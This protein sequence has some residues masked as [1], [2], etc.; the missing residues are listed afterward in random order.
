MNRLQLLLERR[1]AE[2]TQ[3]WPAA[4]ALL[5]L[6]SCVSSGVVWDGRDWDLEPNTEMAENVSSSYFADSLSD[7]SLVS[8]GHQSLHLPYQEDEDVDQEQLM[9][10]AMKLSAA[11]GAEQ[12]YAFHF[13]FEERLD[14]M[15]YTYVAPAATYTFHNADFGTVIH[16]RAHAHLFARNH[17]IRAY[18]L[19]ENRAGATRQ[20]LELVLGWIEDGSVSQDGL[21]P[22]MDRPKDDPAMLWSEVLLVQ[23]AHHHAD[24]EAV[25]LLARMESQLCGIA[26]REDA[27]GFALEAHAKLEPLLIGSAAR[28]RTHLVVDRAGLSIEKPDGFDTQWGTTTQPWCQA[29]GA[30][31]LGAGLSDY[32]W[33]TLGQTLAAYARTDGGGHATLSLMVLPAGT[34]DLEEVWVG[35]KEVYSSDGLTLYE[36]TSMEIEGGRGV[37]Y[38]L[39]RQVDILTYEARTMGEPGMVIKPHWAVVTIG[40]QSSDGASEQLLQEMVESIRWEPDFGDRSLL[41]RSEIRPHNWFSSG[42]Q[43]SSSSFERPSRSVISS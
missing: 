5:L 30:A 16:R 28:M 6:S 29:D 25:G 36:V 12:C 23:Y 2:S 13:S 15:T 10:E 9:D 8:I 21:P 32:S 26:Q 38:V 27:A 42:Y 17:P 20:E 4:A 34:E 7:P 35:A 40:F 24:A 33:Q 41:W 37:S 31:A 3:A 14:N 43:S 22:R 11:A 18:E 19:L 1:S 39:D